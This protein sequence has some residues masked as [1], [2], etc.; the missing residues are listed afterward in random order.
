[1]VSNVQT[2]NFIRHE[3]NTDLKLKPQFFLSNV[4]ESLGVRYTAGDSHGF[5]R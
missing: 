4:A 3:L 1:M 5:S 2:P